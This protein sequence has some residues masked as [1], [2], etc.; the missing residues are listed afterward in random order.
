[1]NPEELATTLNARNKEQEQLLLAVGQC[2]EN[3]VPV[4]RFAR[5]IFGSLVS[6]TISECQRR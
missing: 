1:M 4:F 6:E 3:F 5:W 2:A